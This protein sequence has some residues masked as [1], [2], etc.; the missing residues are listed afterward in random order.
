MKNLLKILDR[1]I[2][3]LDKRNPNTADLRDNYVF[4]QDLF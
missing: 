4:E 1:R 2:K 3:W